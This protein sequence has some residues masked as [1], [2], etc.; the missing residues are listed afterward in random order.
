MN[1]LVSIIM[2]CFNSELFLREAI[3]SVLKQT[4]SNWELIICDDGSTD[5][6]VMVAGEYALLDSRINLIDNTYSKGAPGA[7][8]C[9]LDVASGRYIAF[10]DSDDAWYVD[11]LEQQISFMKTRQIAFCYS[12]HDLM[13]ENA[14]FLGT[15]KAPSEVNSRKMKISN[16]IPCLTA[17]YD[18][19]VL[20]KVYQPEITKRNDFALWLKIL[21]G[22]VVDA[23]YCLPLATAKYRSNSYGLSSNK[24]D[25]LLFFRRCLT[26]YG[27]CTRLE[28]YVYSIFYLVLIVIKKKFINIYNWIAVRV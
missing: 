11:K 21:N 18:S 4:F 2:P 7:R 13:D 16:F 12:Y 22:G 3:D 19:K 28:A 8:N 26:D 10:L 25:S 9:A 17:V 24:L 15:Y 23:A 5:K 6:S 27:Q 20:G 14:S 1:D